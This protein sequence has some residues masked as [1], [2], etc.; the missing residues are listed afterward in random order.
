MGRPKG[1]VVWC[2]D[3]VKDTK[4]ESHSQLFST[5][6]ALRSRCCDDVKDTKNESHSQPPSGFA[7]R[8][9]RCCDDVK[10]TK[11]ES[12]SQLTGRAARWAT[13]VVTMSK[14]QKMKAIHNDSGNRVAIHTEF[15]PGIPGEIPALQKTYRIGISE[16]SITTSKTKL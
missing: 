16:A 10:D 5:R 7:Q 8:R 12:H 15:F 4:N 2:C 6:K 1:K 11:N 3:D 13:G 9:K 14:I